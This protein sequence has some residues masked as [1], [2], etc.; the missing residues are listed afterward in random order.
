[1]DLP[2]YYPVNEFGPAMK[3]MVI[4]TLGVVHVFLAMFAI[5]G[6]MLMC[7]FQWLAQTGRCH[8][9]RQFVDGYFRLLVLISFDY[10][11][12]PARYGCVEEF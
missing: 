9:A 2:P 7:Y 4:G 5:G 3:G 12:V 10:L 1:M 8:N 11:F 6:G